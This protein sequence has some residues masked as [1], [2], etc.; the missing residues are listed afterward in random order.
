MFSSRYF[1]EDDPNIR[2]YQN[3]K[4]SGI[5]AIVSRPVILPYNELTRWA[6]ENVNA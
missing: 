5:H 4:K 2:V 6:Y 3:I 1:L